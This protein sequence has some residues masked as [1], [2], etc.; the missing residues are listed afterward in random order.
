MTIESNNFFTG[1]QGSF[2]VGSSSVGK[3]VGTQNTNGTFTVIYEIDFDQTLANPATPSGLAG[4]TVPADQS[5]TAIGV[6]I[7]DALGNPLLINGTANT[8]VTSGDQIDPSITATEDGGAAF[9]YT[10]GSGD[11]FVEKRDAGGQTVFTTS[12]AVTGAN[13]RNA[14]IAEMNGGRLVVSYTSEQNG[15]KQLFAKFVD[16]TASGVIVSAPIT[17]DNNIAS[18]S[19]TA[20]DVLE[21]GRPAIAYI[22]QGGAVGRVSLLN[23][24]GFG[25]NNIIVANNGN[26]LIDI[27]VA[28]LPN[29]GFVV[30]W[31]EEDAGAD[32]AFVARYDVSGTQIGTTR[33]VT[34]DF[35][36]DQVEVVTAETNAFSVLVDGQQPDGDGSNIVYEYSA[37]GAFQGGQGG[38]Q[39]GNAETSLL[40]TVGDS[41]LVLYGNDNGASSNG[42][43]TGIIYGSREQA[44]GT[45]A[46]D[47]LF[48]NDGGPV[49]TLNVDAGAGDDQLFV[50]VG[51]VAY[52]GGDGIDSIDYS[53]TDKPITL[54]S[55]GV[56]SRSFVNLTFSDVLVGDGFIPTVERIVADTQDRSGN[57]VTGN[58]I[59]GENSTNSQFIVDLQSETLTIIL[60]RPAGT[61]SLVFEVENFDTVRGTGNAD[62]ITGSSA[63]E[64]LFGG[65]GDDLIQLISGT[66]EASGQGGNDRIVGGDSNDDISGGAGVDELFGNDGSDTIDGDTGSDTIFG[67]TGSDT[68]F[69][70]NGADTLEGGSGNDIIDGEG[71]TDVIRGG[72][73]DDIISGGGS[74]DDL[75]GDAGSDDL[76]GNDGSD[77]LSG[78]AGNDGLNGGQGNDE[79]RGGSGNDELLGSTGDDQLYGDDGADT[80]QFRANHG[81]DRIFDFEQGT[82]IIQFNIGSVNDISDLTFTNV[83]AGVDISYGSGSIR[84]LGS[85]DTDFTNADFEFL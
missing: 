36:I 37:S 62:Q 71:F 6:A 17:L 58:T 31:A 85:N 30:T 78:G 72:S 40:Q 11:I 18:Q 23:T 7:L 9:S 35:K 8:A 44:F 3:I 59:D 19:E 74:A 79:L 68:L 60:D 69:G 52:D 55:S 56:I 45:S 22:E 33:Q 5:G 53:L 51:E 80:F 39:G 20:L 61:T 81:S 1:A 49:V 43:Y 77:D 70:G 42:N 54:L 14:D 24:S 82:D 29:G 12:L 25:A 47:V 73:G 4:G 65:G 83:F 57:A 2:S 13:E 64:T 76:F 46:D 75:F 38:G 84:V 28:A 63:D 16:Q 10:S 41:L 48:G 50:N 15:V 34:S 27:D 26:Q 21:D 67:G 66:N 32:K